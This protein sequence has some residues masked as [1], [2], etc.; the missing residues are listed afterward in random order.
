MTLPAGPDPAPAPD[1]APGFPATLLGLVERGAIDDD[2]SYAGAV[3][4]RAL[5]ELAPHCHTITVFPTQEGGADATLTQRGL[6]AARLMSGGR[7]ADCVVYNHLGVA[8]AQWSI[9][10]GMRRAYAVLVHGAEAWDPA[11]D[12]ARRR[13]LA[14]ASL[15]IATSAYTA[16]RVSEAHPDTPQADVLPPTLLPEADGSPVDGALVS[17][18]T[19]RTIVI[20]SRM[21]STERVRGHDEL[22]EAW[23][24]ILGRRPDAR[25]AL[26]GRGDDVKRLE[27]K[28]N[29][30][31]LAGSVRFTG[32]VSE[33]T[34]D[35]MLVKAG[36]FALP[37]REE[38]SGVAYLRAMRA[39]LPCIAG[40]ADAAGELVDDGVTGMLV[41]AA[42]RDA[43]AQAVISLLG[44]SGRR[45]AMGEAGRTRF[46]EHFSF[47]RFRER[48]DGML[49]AAFPAR[50]S[51]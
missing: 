18:I 50:S 7:R 36:G 9:P 34:L 8:T 41:P 15:R 32:H 21:T 1:R 3:L 39:G 16:R 28:A 48:L 46:E 25:L 27:A 29:G 11:I 47:A 42:D 12:A 31:G 51:R 30:L 6:F 45:R 22:L 17:S 40:D 4:E 20:S 33:S 13:A 19:P 14:N 49:R 35:A 24:T 43:V 38:G 26:V 2:V 23:P 37:G 10:A 5:T 44:D